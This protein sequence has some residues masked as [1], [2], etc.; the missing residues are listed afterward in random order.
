MG[1][2][3][4]GF[5]GSLT[6]RCCDSYSTMRSLQSYKPSLDASLWSGPSVSR[7]LYPAKV[8]FAYRSSPIAHTAGVHLRKKPIHED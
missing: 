5:F 3:S 7:V 8:I 2:L 4:G 6:H 1:Y